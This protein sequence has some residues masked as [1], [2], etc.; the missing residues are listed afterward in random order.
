MKERISCPATGPQAPAE[1]AGGWGLVP[2][3]VDCG[4][5]AGGSSAGR[6]VG[7]RLE[8]TDGRMV[9]AR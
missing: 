4:R 1:T 7:S 2:L 5:T 6:G 3:G 9:S 8:G